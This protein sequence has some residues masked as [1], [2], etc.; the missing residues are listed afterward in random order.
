MYDTCRPGFKGRCT[1]PLLVDKVTRSIVSNE[2]SDMLA[3]INDWRLPGASPVELRPPELAAQMAQ[4]ND[5]VRGCVGVCVRAGAALL[6]ARGATE[7]PKVRWCWCINVQQRAAVGGGASEAAGMQPGPYIALK[8]A[9]A[10]QTCTGTGSCGTVCCP[11]LLLRCR[12]R[13]TAT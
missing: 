3:M 12:C 9:Q 11:Q 6:A 4:L 1:A 8:P 13:S 10:R 5:T 2:S 7:R